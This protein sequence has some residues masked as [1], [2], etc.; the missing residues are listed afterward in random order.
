MI[1][2]FTNPYNLFF[3]LSNTEISMRELAIL[4]LLGQ[5]LFNLLPAELHYGPPALLSPKSGRTCIG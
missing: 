1:I 3:L 2:I 5:A 4:K